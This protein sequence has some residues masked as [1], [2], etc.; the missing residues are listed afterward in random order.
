MMD[1]IKSIF[2]IEKHNDNLALFYPGLVDDMC[3]LGG[4]FICTG[5]FRHEIFFNSMINISICKQK[6]EHGVW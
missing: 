6:C 1:F 2:E 4:M 5:D 3:H